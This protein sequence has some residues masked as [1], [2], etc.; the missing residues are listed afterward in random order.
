MVDRIVEFDND[1]K[2]VIL[3]ETKLDNVVY[4]IGLRLD[5]REEPTTNYLFFEEIKDDNQVFL[6]PVNDET[7]KNVLLTSFTMN[8]L[9]MAYDEI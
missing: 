8:Y 7:T 2:Y 6:N 1:K 5:D 9:E 3:D 4:Y